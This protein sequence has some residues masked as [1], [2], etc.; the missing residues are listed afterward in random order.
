MLSSVELSVTRTS[1]MP[2]VYLGFIVEKHREVGN[3]AMYAS[4]ERVVRQRCIQ[5]LMIAHEATAFDECI[6]RLRRNDKISNFFSLLIDNSP[7]KK[8]QRHAVIM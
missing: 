2:T 7:M 4:H 5:I 8:N 3:T 1:K 6:A